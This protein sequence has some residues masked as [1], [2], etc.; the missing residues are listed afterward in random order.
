MRDAHPLPRLGI[1]RNKPIDDAG[2]GDPIVAQRRQKRQGAP[3]AMRHF[4]DPPPPTEATPVPSGHGGLGP[5]FVD[6]DQAS[7]VKS[8]LMRLPPDPAAGDVGAV[9]LAGV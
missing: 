9:L 8:A 3:A 1:G 5:G 7:Q 4:S 6:E 2:R